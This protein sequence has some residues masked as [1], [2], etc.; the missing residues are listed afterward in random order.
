MLRRSRLQSDWKISG[1]GF[2]GPPD[3]STTSPSVSPLALS[4]ILYYDSRATESRLLL[5]RLR[6][7]LDR[8]HICRS[9]LLGAFD[10]RIV[11]LSTHV[12]SL[13]EQQYFGLQAAL[14]FSR[15]HAFREQW[16]PVIVISSQGTGVERP[17]TTDHETG[18]GEAHCTGFTRIAIL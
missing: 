9:L 17:T 15:Y 6:P 2:C 16:L 1:F 14:E 12:S 8:C 13:H 5:S 3:R 7:R 4:E 18:G 11:Q 10:R